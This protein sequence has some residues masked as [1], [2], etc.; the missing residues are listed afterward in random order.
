[1]DNQC[2]M[3]RMIDAK[4]FALVELG[5]FL[6]THPNDTNALKMR[7]QVQKQVE[8]LMCEYEKQFGP[9]IVTQNDVKGNCDCWCWVNNPWPWDYVK[10]V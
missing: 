2:R 1:M 7:S 6:D 8:D 9:M 5:L 4:E 3:R 10:E